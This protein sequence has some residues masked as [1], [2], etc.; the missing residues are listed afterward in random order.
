M[1]PLFKKGSGKEV[2]GFHQVVFTGSKK[3]F[4]SPRIFQK[5]F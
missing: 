2:E 3:G 5:F 1:L 4:S